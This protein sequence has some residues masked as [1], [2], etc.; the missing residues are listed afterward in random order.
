MLVV[1]VCAMASS[2]HAQRCDAQAAIM[3][4]GRIIS[5]QK[6]DSSKEASQI[7]DKLQAIIPQNTTGGEAIG[8]YM[9]AAQAEEFGELRSRLVGVQLNLLVDSEY[10]RDL[11]VVSGML[12]I[13]QTLHEGKDIAK[14]DETYAAVLGALGNAGYDD[15]PTQPTGTCNLYTAVN[16]T[17]AA[18]FSQIKID[19]A[20]SDADNATLYALSQKYHVQ[21]YEIMKANLS[22]ADS[23]IAAPSFGRLQILARE[24]QYGENLLR[25]AYFYRTDQEI[26]SARIKSMSLYGA[27]PDTVDRVLDE[28]AKTMKP[29]DRAYMGVWSAVN[30][31]IPSMQSKNNAEIAKVMAVFEKR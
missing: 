15:T 28:E 16:E 20:N 11:T 5:K 27:A 6:V 17:E 23:L 3:Q 30:E 14:D 21:S 8:K 2:A 10:E 19:R 13:A 31:K 29:L 25:I 26:H 4:D 22:S 12:S 9:T 24:I 1:G 7:S 18:L